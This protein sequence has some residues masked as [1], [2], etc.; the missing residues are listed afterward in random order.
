MMAGRD[1]GPDRRRLLTAGLAVPLGITTLHLPPASAAAS[2]FPSGALLAAPVAAV[3]TT[4]STAT[5]LLRDVADADAVTYRVDGGAVR[6]I[7][8]GV[9]EVTVTSLLQTSHLITVDWTTA[10]GTASSRVSLTRTTATYD[11]PS[12]VVDVMISDGAAMVREIGFIVIGGAGGRGGASSDGRSGGWGLFPD[13]LSGR[14]AVEEGDTLRIAVGGGGGAGT[15]A[16]PYGIGGAGGSNP[17]PGNLHRGGNGGY[18]YNRYNVS[19]GGAGGGGGAASVLRRI[20][21]G[22]ELDVAVAAGAGGGGGAYRIDSGGLAVPKGQYGVA[23]INPYGLNGQNSSANGAGGGGGGGL[24]GGAGG[25]SESNSWGRGGEQGS[26]GIT[27]LDTS[28]TLI[29][30]PPVTRTDGQNG[31]VTIEMVTATIE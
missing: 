24:R 15:S 19:P 9:D 31:E 12:G 1:P 22:V 4:L 5:L 21:G 23:S 27:G 7:A 14:L 2:P 3:T 6:S 13:Q 29:S 10:G 17:L 20:R 30:T 8:A 25:P 16:V 26:S 28:G 18:T 11:D